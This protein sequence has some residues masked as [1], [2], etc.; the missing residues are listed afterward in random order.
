LL[1]RMAYP[2]TSDGMF[3]IPSVL[4][5]PGGFLCYMATCDMPTFTLDLR[6]S[7]CSFMVCD[8][9]NRLHLPLQT[10]FLLPAR[11]PWNELELGFRR[12]SFGTLCFLHLV[13]SS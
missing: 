6:L 8:P 11:S 4:F 13:S 1:A 2:A 7:V 12:R 9:S 10:L 5:L 3:K